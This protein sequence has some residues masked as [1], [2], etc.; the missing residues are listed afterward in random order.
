MADAG[1][2]TSAQRKNHRTHITGGRNGD[3]YRGWNL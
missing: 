1:A 2:N 3:S